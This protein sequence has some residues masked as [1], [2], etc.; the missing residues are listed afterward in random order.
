MQSSSVQIIIKH[1]QCDRFVPKRVKCL[2]PQLTT[3]EG[4]EHSCDALR[5]LRLCFSYLQR[6]NSLVIEVVTVFSHGNNM[7]SPIKLP[8]YETEILR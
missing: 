6:H 7:P 3:A 1:N 2:I 4:I 5:S 8:G